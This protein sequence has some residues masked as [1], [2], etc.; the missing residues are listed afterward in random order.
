MTR[1]IVLLVSTLTA[2]IALKYLFD[3]E[4]NVAPP[5]YS[6]STDLLECQCR[7][8]SSLLKLGALTRLFNQNPEQ[9]WVRSLLNGETGNARFFADSE[10]SPVE[11]LVSEG[12]AVEAR[13]KFSEFMGAQQDRSFFCQASPETLTI[14]EI[15]ILYSSDRRDTIDV[16]V[17][18]AIEI[19]ETCLRWGVIQQ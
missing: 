6:G 14:F 3:S 16:A 19:R 18:D 2:F 9:P 17:S 13:I 7:D 10:P 8:L 11:I 12:G 4:P 15:G 1:I 5:R